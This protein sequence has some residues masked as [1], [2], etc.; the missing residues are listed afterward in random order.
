MTND[1]DPDFPGPIDAEWIGPDDRAEEG[2]GLVAFVVGAA[3]LS[4]VAIA[5]L[6]WGGGF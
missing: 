1:P 6:A 4:A 2:C 3:I 5:Y